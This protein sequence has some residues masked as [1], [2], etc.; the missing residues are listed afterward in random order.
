MKNKKQID[1]IIINESMKH[2]SEYLNVSYVY[3]NNSDEVTVKHICDL[4]F[5]KTKG[6]YELY[7]G[8]EFENA[9]YIE[10][11]AQTMAKFQ[12]ERVM[13]FELLYQKSGLNKEYGSLLGIINKHKE[14]RVTSVIYVFAKDIGGDIN[15][16]F[17]EL[18]S[19][20]LKIEKEISVNL[21]NK[22]FLFNLI[23]SKPS[24]NA[25][26]DKV[27]RTRDIIIK[28]RDQ[29]VRNEIEEMKEELNSIDED[30]VNYD[31]L[32]KDIPESLSNKIIIE[33]ESDYLN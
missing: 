1:S 17:N 21:I 20:V 2:G 24:F 3:F 6:F 31:E 18:F 4:K 5:N 10:I 19:G 7:D 11:E 32:H 29:N 27:E 26:I 33:T 23:F 30:E 25:I 12:Y 28:K 16:P 13:S 14:S 8:D 15:I 22:E 9:A